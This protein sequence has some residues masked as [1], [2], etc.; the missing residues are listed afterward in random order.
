MVGTLRELGL[1]IS[2]RDR[3]LAK[4]MLTTAA[5]TTRAFWKKLLPL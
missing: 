2:D 3:M 1:P 4:D 5:F